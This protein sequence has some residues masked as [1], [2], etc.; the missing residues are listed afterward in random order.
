MF[1]TGATTTDDVSFM[2]II[3]IF[4]H[5]KACQAISDKIDVIQNEQCCKSC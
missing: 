4:K 3:N 1:T 2:E 5:F